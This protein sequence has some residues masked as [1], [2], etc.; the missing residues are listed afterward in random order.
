MKIIIVDTNRATMNHMVRNLAQMYP[1]VQLLCADNAADTLD[2]PVEDVEIAFLDT[3]LPDMD[4]IEALKIIRGDASSLNK[5]TP[6]IALTANAVFG[7]KEMFLENGF[8][9]F[10]AKPFDGNVLMASSDDASL[11]AYNNAWLKFPNMT[12]NLSYTWNAQNMVQYEK[13]RNGRVIVGCTAE[14]DLL[15]LVVEKF[16]NTHNQGQNCTGFTPND[17]GHNGNNNDSRGLDFYESAKVMTSNIV[18]EISISRR[19][20]TNAL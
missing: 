13:L 17:N 2:F 4:G 5:E 10:I 6:V 18:S 12:Q 8:D 20:L 1:R 3:D 19:V 16:V 11:K 15:I 7:A 9:D 14:G